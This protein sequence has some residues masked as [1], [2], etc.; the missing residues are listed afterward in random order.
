[1]QNKF[2]YI[3]SWSYNQLYLDL[4]LFRAAEW[5]MLDLWAKL[6]MH[7]KDIVSGPLIPANFLCLIFSSWLAPG[8]CLSRLLLRPLKSLINGHE[9]SS[10]NKQICVKWKLCEYEL[11]C[12]KCQWNDE[13]CTLCACM[14]YWLSSFKSLS[15][16]IFIKSCD[17]PLAFSVSVYP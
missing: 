5:F 6:S 12:S 16:A 7:K 2:Y 13:L 9:L 17:I 10:L 15:L 4:T 11:D 1:M 8:S 14:A 3:K